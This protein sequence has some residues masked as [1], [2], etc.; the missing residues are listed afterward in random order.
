MSRTEGKE[1][2]ELI[3]DK[4]KDGDRNAF[5]TIYN[6]FADAM[7]SYGIR[8]TRHKH[9]VKDAIQDT[10]LDIYSYKER[11][12]K[13]ES[14]EFYLYKSLKNNIIKKLKEKNRFALT[15]NFVTQFELAFPLEET[16]LNEP[17]EHISLLKSELESLDDKKKE[18]LFLKFTS[19]LTYKE[20]GELLDI[21]SD[22]VKKQIYRTLKLLRGKLG[23]NF[24]QLFMIFFKG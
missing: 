18:L 4:F 10:F 1:Y 6:E 19:G 8:F 12:R 2:W 16:V 5:E 17:E 15:D 21:K 20:I 22:T 3:W 14:L 7:F 9:L 23:D 24:M 13:P 11:L